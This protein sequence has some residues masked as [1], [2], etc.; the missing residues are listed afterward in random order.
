MKKIILTFDDGP[1][2]EFPELLDYL[3][4]K[5]HKAVFFCLGQNLEKQ[6]NQKHLIRAI[7]N[8]FI[9]ANHSYSHPSFNL[10]SFNKGKREMIKTDKII[11]GLYEKAGRRQRI[12]MFRF[13]FFAE[14]GI[15]FRKYQKLL[16]SLGYENP[17]FKKRTKIKKQVKHSLYHLVQG[18]RRGKEDVYCDIDPADWDKKTSWKKIKEV[19]SKSEDRDVLNLHDQK[20]NFETTKKICEYLS[21]KGFK[22]TT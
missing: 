21:E 5:N 7:K 4:K 14:G 8:N 13:P 2:E 3:I 15:N 10:I 11:S 6:E 16:E 9:I 17:Y 19:L 18:F 12:K 1:S 20:N 22:L